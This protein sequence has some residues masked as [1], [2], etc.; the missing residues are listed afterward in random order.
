MLTLK[1]WPCVLELRLQ[2]FQCDFVF[3]LR[4]S[5][6]HFWGCFV[7]L[8]AFLL[9]FVVFGLFSLKT[10]CILRFLGFS[11]MT[12]IFDRFDPMIYHV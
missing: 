8:C 1:S 9:V 7:C 12:A 6:V 3:G 2:G 10:Q 4:I 11:V 5:G